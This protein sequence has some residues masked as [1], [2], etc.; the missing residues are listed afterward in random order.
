MKSEKGIFCLQGRHSKTRNIQPVSWKQAKRHPETTANTL[1]PLTPKQT[2]T[3]Q[4]KKWGWGVREEAEKNPIFTSTDTKAGVFYHP[5]Q[6]V[7]A[8][9]YT[10]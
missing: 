1:C 6:Q 10:C 3:K 7:T 8:L 2:K 4:E 9:Q 5:P